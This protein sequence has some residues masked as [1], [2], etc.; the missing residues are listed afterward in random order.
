V[1]W[2][3]C[4]KYHKEGFPGKTHGVLNAVE[5]YGRQYFGAAGLQL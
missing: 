4:E 5:W 3:A 2:V 1:S